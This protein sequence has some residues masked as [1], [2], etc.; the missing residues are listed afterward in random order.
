MFAIALGKILLGGLVALDILMAA[1]YLA[2]DSEIALW[3][4]GL[5]LAGGLAAELVD[6]LGK[7]EHERPAN[8][9]DDLRGYF[10]YL[11]ER[12][13]RMVW[14][15]AE[16]TLVAAAAHLFINMN[17]SGSLD[18]WTALTTRIWS[19]IGNVEFDW[20]WSIAP[21]A[22]FGM[23]LALFGLGCCQLANHRLPNRVRWM[24]WCVV[25][26]LACVPVALRAPPDC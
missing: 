12:S 20:V 25:S 11:C 8:W 7:A 24:W 19:D 26:G 2:R 13:G 4:L 15:W 21:L 23:A 9:T 22:F 16:W 17:T 14:R 3:W 5:L 10:N 18:S 6:R 1:N